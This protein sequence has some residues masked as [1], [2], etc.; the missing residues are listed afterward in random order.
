MP[1]LELAIQHFA[2]PRI[3]DFVDRSLGR[4]TEIETE[5]RRHAVVGP[6]RALWVFVRRLLVELLWNVATA[7]ECAAWSLRCST[8][9][10]TS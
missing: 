9:C 5:L 4:Y 10:T 1:S 3:S 8:P 6:L 7:T 2:Y